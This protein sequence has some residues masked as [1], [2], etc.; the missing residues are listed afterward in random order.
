ME[1]MAQKSDGYIRWRCKSCNQKLKV[2]DTY[3]GG[4]VIQCPRCGASVNVPLI[5]IEAI[6]AGADMPE[7]GQPGRLHIDREKLMDALQGDH[8]DPDAP[9]TVGS[10][11][12]VHRG[13][14]DPATAF[15]RLDQLDQVAASLVKIDQ[16]VMGEVQRVF[17]NPDLGPAE[18]QAQVQGA[19]ET[20]RSE[21]RRLVQDRLA[22]MRLQISQMEGVRSKLMRSQ[23]VELE[24]LVLAV[25]ALELYTR[26]VLGVEL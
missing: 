23:L 2:R 6:A 15:G 3:E 12:S 19:A 26:H 10:S 20:R 5:N 18:R 4:N 25:E 1:A 24:R 8:R 22:G 17:R 11:P 21:I 7:T 13:N 16:N 9:G 14:W